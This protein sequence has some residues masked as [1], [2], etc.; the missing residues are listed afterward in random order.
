MPR[1]KLEPESLVVESYETAAADPHNAAPP[2]ITF[3]IT[4]CPPCA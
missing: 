3:R 1:I 2:T 4:S